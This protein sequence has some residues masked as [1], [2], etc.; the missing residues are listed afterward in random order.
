VGRRR[1]ANDQDA[2]A[3]IAEA[4]DRPCPVALAREARR[5]LTPDLLAPRN[6]S[7]A[8]HAVDYLGVDFV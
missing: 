2:R 4:R 3:G 7:R 8:A 6:E 5:R 1:E